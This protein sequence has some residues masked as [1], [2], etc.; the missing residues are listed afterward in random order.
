MKYPHIQVSIEEDCAHQEV[1]KPERG[2]LFLSRSVVTRR[3][4]EIDIPEWFS[5][6]SLLK[7]SGRF[8]I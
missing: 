3:E 2:F 1:V 8:F 6:Y 5:P 7:P 4:K